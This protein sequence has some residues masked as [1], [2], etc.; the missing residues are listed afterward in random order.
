MFSQI[1]R[2]RATYKVDLHNPKTIQ[3]NASDIENPVNGRMFVLIHH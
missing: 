2:P 1:S 3:Q